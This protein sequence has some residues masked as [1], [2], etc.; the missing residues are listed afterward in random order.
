MSTDRYEIVYD[1]RYWWCKYRIFRV[2]V[3]GDR[4]DCPAMAQHTLARAIGIVETQIKVR[5]YEQAQKEA[6]KVVWR[7]EDRFTR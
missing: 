4:E 6:V 3:G 2:R 7:E 5:D 1:P